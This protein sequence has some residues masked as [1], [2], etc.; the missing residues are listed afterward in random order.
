MWTQAL[1]KEPDRMNL[2]DYVVV[3]SVGFVE[4]DEKLNGQRRSKS[5]NV[6]HS[7]QYN[8][9]FELLLNTH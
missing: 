6:I 7:T 9:S 4:G 8:I 3:D 1:S 2:M 5:S